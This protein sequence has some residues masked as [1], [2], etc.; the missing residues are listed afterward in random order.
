V[1]R[2]RRVGVVDD[3]GKK[4][5][6][7]AGAACQH[8]LKPLHDLLYDTL[9]EQEWLLRG[10]PKNQHLKKFLIKPGEVFVSGDY[11]AATDNFNRRHSHAILSMV[12]DLAGNDI[13]K[14]VKAMA[15]DR[16]EPGILSY[17]NSECI[18]QS[19]QLMGDLLSFP[20][21][22]LTNYLAFRYAIPRDV[23]LLINGDDIVFRCTRAEYE[24]WSRCV[25]DAGL[26]LSKGKTLIHRI[27]FSINS[28]FYQARYKKASLVPVIRARMVYGAL[29]KGDG[30]ALEARLTGACRGFSRKGKSLIEKHTLRF[31]RG[32]VQGVPCS[33][34]RGLDLRVD[35]S[36]ICT[37]G[38]KDHESYYA[39]QPA[40]CDR[41]PACKG[42]DSPRAVPGWVK[43]AGKGTK[44]GEKEYRRACVQHAWSFESCKVPV[45]IDADEVG[46]HKMVRG[47]GKRMLERTGNVSSRHVNR[48]VV[49]SLKPGWKRI[50]DRFNCRGGRRKKKIER[51]WV[52]EIGRECEPWTLVQEWVLEKE[53]EEF[54]E[55]ISRP[56]RA[57]LRHLDTAF[58]GLQWVDWGDGSYRGHDMRPFAERKPWIAAGNFD[59]LQDHQR[60][61]E[62]EREIV[63]KDSQSYSRPGI[64]MLN[65]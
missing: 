2:T 54:R 55:G 35:P 50:L 25:A 16:L 34:S 46:C 11:E 40:K 5:V 51:H 17:K 7:T 6:I 12:L 33:L 28:M 20:L 64:G 23:P 61:E 45:E 36:V 59:D 21:L 63:G 22:C 44:E 18:Q 56:D 15:L 39:S 14:G 57:F 42:R 3:K 8:A 10:T 24:V 49:A 62:I 30:I 52:Q 58:G 19:G 65:Y 60:R 31:H 4:R 32:A 27:Y 41:R 48:L 37:V 9:S 26:T 13:S 29:I 43:V 53:R 47:V 38:L 1:S